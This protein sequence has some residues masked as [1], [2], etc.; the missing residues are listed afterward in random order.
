MKKG[1]L[2][3]AGHSV[4]SIVLAASLVMPMTGAAYADDASAVKNSAAEVQAPADASV[5][6]ASSSMAVD[7]APVAI[8]AEQSAAPDAVAGESAV[9]GDAPEATSPAE[10]DEDSQLGP[11]AEKGSV[12]REDGL[13]LAQNTDDATE[14]EGAQSATVTGDCAA[15][16][17]ADSGEDGYTLW[18][19][20]DSFSYYY[21]G[22][23]RTSK[24]MTI[25]GGPAYCIE[26]GLDCNT[27]GDPHWP[28]VL[29]AGQA[30]RY[31]LIEKYMRD[32]YDSWT[33]YVFTQYAIWCEIDGSSSFGF[34]YD[35]FWDAY[36]AALDFCEANADRYAATGTKY[37]C[38]EW[39]KV[40]GSFSLTE[41]PAGFKLTK[42]SANTAVTCDNA[43]YSL[44]GT[45]YGLYYYKAD[46]AS[47]KTPDYTIVV[48]ADGS[49]DTITG[50]DVGDGNWY[51]KELT[52]GKGYKLDGE[53]YDVKLAY[54][55]TTTFA[56][57]DEPIVDPVGVMLKKIKA[58]GEV[59]KGEDGKDV[60]LGGAVYRFAYY[61]SL[62]YDEKDIPSEFTR[63]WF[64]RTNAGG[65]VGLEYA[66]TNMVSGYGV[67]SPLY[68]DSLTSLPSIPYGTLVIK[69]IEAPDG[70]KLS[71]ETFIATMRPA[72]NDS[73]IEWVWNKSQITGNV[74]IA[75]EST[76]TGSLVIQKTSS[77]PDVSQGNSNYTLAGA[78][79]EIYDNESCSGEPEATVT[80]GE[81]GATPVVDKLAPYGT[82]YVK[83][84]E[85]P[86]GFE[87]P[88]E[89]MRIKKVEVLPGK[90]GTTVFEYSDKPITG[91]G[92]VV[93]V[94]TNPSLTVNNPNY[95]LAGAVFSVWK[96]NV[97]CTGEPDYRLTTK[98]DGTTDAIAGL[99]I[100]TTL[101]FKETAAP[102]NFKDYP[103]EPKT[104]TIAA[105][106]TETVEFA[107]EPYLG[108]GSLVKR[109][110]NTDITEG[111]PM[112]SLAGARYGVYADEACTDKVYELVTDENGVTNKFEN[113]Y[114]GST[115]Y[116]KEIKASE[117]YK[118]DP[119][120]YTMDITS[121]TQEAV[122]EVEEA[123][124]FTEAE[125][126]LLKIDADGDEVAELGDATLA[127]AVYEFS[128]FAG[129]T[130]AEA[131]AQGATP[132]VVWEGKTDADG[133]VS[134]SDSI[135]TEGIGW[136]VSGKSVLP[137]GTLLIKEK[138]PSKGFLISA[139]KFYSTVSYDKDSETAVWGGDVVDPAKVNEEGRVLAN[140]S[141]MLF[142]ISIYKTIQGVE[143]E[144]SPEGITFEVVYVGEG[145]G[146]GKVYAELVLDAEGK[147]STSERALPLG[148]YEVREVEST[149]PRND[150]GE[151]LIQPYSHTSGDGSNVVA[152]VDSSKLDGFPLYEVVKTDCV[153][154][155]SETFDGEKKDKDTGDVIANTEFTLWSYTG[156]LGMNDGTIATDP[157]TLDAYGA[158]WTKIATIITDKNGKFDFGY[159]PYG[160]Y[161]VA[162]TRPEWHYQN[163][164]ES[165]AG[166]V[167]AD[168]LQ[169]ARIFKVD[170]DTPYEIQLWED[171]A[172]DIACSVDKSTIDV[173]S[174]GLSFK[175]SSEDGEDITNVGIEDYEYRVSFASESNTYGDEFWVI[176][177][178]N[179]TSSPYD[180]RVKK[181]V[182][183]TTR[184]D[185]KAGA[186]VLY[187]TNKGGAGWTPEVEAASVH[188][189]TLCDGASRFDGA[190]WTCLGYYADGVVLDTADF[191][192]ADGEY[193]T[194]LC[195]YYGAVEKGFETISPL[196]YLI[197]AT[198][199]LRE[200]IVIPNTATS[201]ISRNWAARSGSVGGLSDD[202]RD[203]VETTVLGTFEVAFEYGLINRSG[204]N[205]GTWMPKTGD[206]AGAI[207]LAMAG[208][209]AIAGVATAALRRREK[210]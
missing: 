43:M 60:R 171:V 192:L 78:K 157:A 135:L 175:S 144:A 110:A 41:Q 28:E 97:E 207:A 92:G 52:A 88:A 14:P 131:K 30:L 186:Y 48:N 80:T 143:N 46:A 138:S 12:S 42:S 136:T 102:A 101:T 180:L 151:Y 47:G 85:A 169:T 74:A 156:D 206:G 150:K 19:E 139:E 90:Q 173:T 89:N 197:T 26:N 10:P 21:N 178:L 140:E 190:D 65:Y 25:A 123:P 76:D 13:M 16:A 153:D 67:N 208:L 152:V 111:N 200:G 54:G 130:E 113:L 81:N 193:L 96:N 27:K 158:Y 87:L 63:A 106:A 17:L 168:P 15:E 205:I 147:A 201:H 125:A 128:F 71:G 166:G 164:A 79:F 174:A 159:Q 8:Q 198:H 118:T 24:F 3:K 50:I 35:G 182:L 134:L 94:S 196:Q 133:K 199:E 68:Y 162:E 61:G 129:K 116:V 107:D 55:R 176:D 100:G 194:G 188:A 137:L 154:Y 184:G 37:V 148:T 109:S 172:I 57:V 122:V 36:L 98:E 77:D 204:G 51:V 121:H 203:S 6:E 149:L 69:E 95:S 108:V 99:P 66:E 29:D 124:V 70:Y 22:G 33:A 34:Y 160:I 31:A 163:N 170:K 18:I 11:P 23:V 5:G 161:M 167:E 93:K 39:Q 105:N 187:R 75:E 45:T 165:A 119:N 40:V 179:M 127:G 62:F 177:E 58:N 2:A 210:R 86:G 73:Q 202:D 4:L 9:S 7:E 53:V 112:Y 38:E 44:E 114:I 82:F 84:I 120:V 189:G 117:G 146:N 72:A 56:A 145:E 155:A 132:D 83:E 141:K 126:K 91:S 181:I 183:P 103:G 209:A 191:G 185:S 59:Y 1:F 64:L 142:G 195:L 104:I 49:A 115:Y 32:N 20:P